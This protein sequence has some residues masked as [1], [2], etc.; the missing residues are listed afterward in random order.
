MEAKKLFTTYGKH[1][2]IITY[3]YRGERYD[4][5]YARDWSYCVP[6]A[7]VQ[8]K[9][10]QA[11]IDALIEERNKPQTGNGTD[12]DEVWKLLEDTWE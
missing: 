11:R 1:S 12:W 6:S 9:D 7:R 3:E 2:T 5:E 8:H 4:V 10:A